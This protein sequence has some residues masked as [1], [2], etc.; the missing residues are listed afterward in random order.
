M[1]RLRGDAMADS[2]SALARES[3][4]TS[5][6]NPIAWQRDLQQEHPLPHCEG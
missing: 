2:L 3:I 6:P 5:I 1:P 4:L